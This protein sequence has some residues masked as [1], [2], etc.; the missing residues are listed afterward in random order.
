MSRDRIELKQ[1]EQ[2]QEFEEL[3]ERCKSQDWGALQRFFEIYSIE[4]YNFP[5]RAFHFSEEDAGDFFLFA[6]ERLRDGKRFKTYRGNASFRTWFYSVLRNLVMDWFRYHKKFKNLEYIPFEQFSKEFSFNMQ[7][8]EGYAIDIFYK[9]LDNL[10]PQ[11]R[12]VFKL[13]YLFYLNLEPKDIEILKEVYG[14]ENFEILSFISK[15]KDYLVKKNQRLTEKIERLQR[16]HKKYLD[17]K[18]KESELMKHEEDSYELKEI[19]EKLKEWS[20]NRIKVLERFQKREL[21]IRV[22]FHKI[23]QFLKISV[24]TVSQHFKKANE[25]IRQSQELKKFLLI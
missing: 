2:T 12:I 9:E 1:F 10:E 11:S 14:K 17:L 20:L 19:K 7:E 21:L 13:V 23:A 15:T 24:P 6:F 4:I 18:R 5:I 8:D 16:M 25:K 22:P 3:I